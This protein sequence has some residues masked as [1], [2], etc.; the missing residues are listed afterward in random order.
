MG[1]FYYKYLRERIGFLA[2]RMRKFLY[3]MEI[4]RARLLNTRDKKNNTV[5]NR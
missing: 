4:G 5:S 2:K 1:Y 3:E